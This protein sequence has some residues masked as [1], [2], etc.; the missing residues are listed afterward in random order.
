MRNGAG[1]SEKM[2]ECTEEPTVKLEDSQSTRC[3]L[4]LQ[5]PYE[6][7]RSLLDCVVYCDLCEQYPT[8]IGVLRDLNRSDRACATTPN[9][10]RQIS[11]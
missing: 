4:Q 10:N 1:T 11:I 5:V 3:K 8:Y 2:S 6:A 7:R 9:T